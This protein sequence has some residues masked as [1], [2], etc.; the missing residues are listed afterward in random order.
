MNKITKG[1][2]HFVEKAGVPSLI[3]SAIALVL[4][5]ITSFFGHPEKDYTGWFAWIV[6]FFSKSILGISSIF[7]NSFGIGII[8]FTILARTFVLPLMIYQVGSS[9]NMSLATPEIKPIQEKYRGKRD[10]ASMQAMQAETNAVYKK[11]GV[12][13]YASLL[14]LLIQL[15]ILMALYWAIYQTPELRQ[16]SFLWFQLGGTDPYFV[17]PILAALFTF[18]SSW[19]SMA[20]TEN[21]PGFTKAMPYIFPVIIFFTALSFPTALSL[22]WVVGNFYQAVQTY[23]LQN[24]FKMR[25]ERREKKAAEIAAHRAIEKKKRKLRNKK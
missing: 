21:A 13:P 14:P 9:K 15:P 1:F 22:Y 7:G 23:F 24:P 5:I 4:I 2:K 20:S 12:N 16:G 25:R 11:Y 6:E 3:T 17:L 18:V 10:S 8:V 19:M